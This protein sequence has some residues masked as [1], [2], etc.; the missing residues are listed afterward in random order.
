MGRVPPRFTFSAEEFERLAQPKSL[1]L[2]ESMTLMPFRA[3]LQLFCEGGD[4]SYL[5]SFV[6]LKG[7]VK[8]VRRKPRG[9]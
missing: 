9:M 2:R 6:E 3:F 1:F 5:A 4:W 8:E 7:V